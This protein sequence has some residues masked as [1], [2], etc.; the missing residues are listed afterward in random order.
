MRPR[1]WPD[2]THTTS[3]MFNSPKFTS[4]GSVRISQ[5]LF[6]C[7]HAVHAARRL[8]LVGRLLLC[9]STPCM[10]LQHGRG[11]LVSHV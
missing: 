6:S 9:T 8:H 1:P 4:R 3:Y 7:A 2:K 10:Q 5:P 11:V